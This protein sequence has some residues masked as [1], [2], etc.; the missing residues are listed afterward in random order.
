MKLKSKVL[1]GLILIGFSLLPAEN[2][3]A[4][5]LYSKSDGN[6]VGS[7]GK[8][9]SSSGLGGVSSSG[10]NASDTSGSGL[11]RAGGP[12]CD[13]CTGDG[14]DGDPLPNSELDPIGEGILILSILS[15]AYA[16][17]KKKFIKNKYEN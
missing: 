17:V 15:G 16:I 12:P 6:K 7:V 5:G 11:F 3:M 8:S 9:D 2:T 13:T 10:L 4:Q 1:I 14:K